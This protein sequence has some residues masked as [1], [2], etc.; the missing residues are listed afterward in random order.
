MLDTYS[1]SKIAIIDQLTRLEGIAES[2]RVKNVAAS[3]RIKLKANIFSLVVVGQF[4]RGK[5]T[6]INA[7]LGKNL[8]P[9]AVIPLTSI[10]TVISYGKAL[11]ITAFF[12]SGAKKEIIL[13]DLA[14]YVTE[15]HNPKNEK[16]IDRVE[17]TY[18]SQYL[19]NGVQIIDTPGIAS[20]H[21]HNT[22]TTY[23]YLPR[24]DA[25]IFL[26]SVDPPLTQA[27]LGFL[28]DLK[29]LVVKTFFIQNKI[30]A[31][32]ASD[33]KESLAFSKEIIEKE[34]GFSDIT[35]YPLS[36]KEALEGK[37]QGSQKKLEM[38]GL[39]RFEEALEQFLMNEKGAT[40]LRST[41]EK[42][43][44]CISEEML[45]AELEQKSIQLPLNALEKKI[46]SF[47]K[48][49]EDSNHEKTDSGRLLAEE[50][51]ELQ[52]ETLTRDLEKLKNEK[53][54]WLVAKVGE[55][56]KAH[57]SDGNTKFIEQMNA[58]IDEQIRDIF[59][60][61]RA[62][63]EKV[64]KQDLNE[65]VQRFT[66]RMNKVLKGI[67]VFS[68]ELFGVAGQEFHIQETLP[69]EIEFRF[70]TKDESD[71]LGMTIDLAK[72]ALPKVLAHRLLL[73]EAEE[74]AERM[75]DR[76]CG[77]T[78]YDFSQRTEQFVRLYRLSV[79]ETLESTQKDVLH[80]LETGLAAKQKVVTE[81]A[82]Q[83]AQISDKIKILKEIKKSLDKLAV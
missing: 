21:E 50:V 2:E 77:K 74:H 51:K 61:W 13:N 26:V 42:T 81:T 20:I 38:S 82:A 47:N 73:K 19:K 3:L 79:T 32:S 57:K 8:L 18:P 67:T 62:E 40:L 7:L 28:H 33:Q 25:A 65:I 35:I 44:G 48:F 36:A 55:F 80:A 37:G 75:I 15:K 66:D 52:T 12:E 63:E 69:P 5:T 58:F 11:K 9:I 49:I 78:R 59:G 22:K 30:D 23:E 68:A 60:T 39:A 1:N 17:I 70:E 14:S 24:A 29:N 56:A 41:I 16:K 72:K 83:G 34:A 10:I 53:T 43:N 45:L 46:A 71:M 76:H 6:F 27:E 54:K 4:K 64:L 31:V